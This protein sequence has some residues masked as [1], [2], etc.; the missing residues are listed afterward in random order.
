MQR[1]AINEPY[2]AISKRLEPKQQKTEVKHAQ[3]KRRPLLLQYNG[4]RSHDATT[5]SS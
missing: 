2:M 1:Y 3:P 5:R 4:I